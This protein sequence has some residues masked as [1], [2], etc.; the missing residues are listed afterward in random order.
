MRSHV[1]ALYAS[2][3]H[4]EN[5]FTDQS[6]PLTISLQ[7][8][9]F[10][11]W[12]NVDFI[13]EAQIIGQSIQNVNGVTLVLLGFSQDILRHHHE[14]LLLQGKD[15]CVC[16]SASQAANQYTHHSRSKSPNYSSG[17]YATADA[18]MEV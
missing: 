11:V 12:S 10:V 17:H 2:Y 14:W 7:A 16:Q 6:V 3:S 8:A 18:H 13:L 4:L 9:I 5:Q 15:Q 1:C